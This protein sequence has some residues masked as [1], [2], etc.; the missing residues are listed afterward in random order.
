MKLYFTRHGESLA[1]TL[2]VISNRELPHPLTAKGRE[3]ATMLASRVKDKNIAR[4][5]A[6]PVPRAKE[7][8]EI[9]SKTLNVPLEISDALREYDCGVLEGRGDREAWNLHRKYLEDWLEGRRRNECP[10]GGE[11]FHD[12]EKRFVPFIKKLVKDYSSNDENLLLVSHG[13]AIL[14]GLPLIL[15]NIDF[16]SARLLPLDNTVIITTESSRD[17]LICRT[18]GEQVL[19]LTNKK[20]GVSN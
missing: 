10:P 11:T 7:T 4:I 18:W 6:S 14:L 13:G 9:I 20:D 2:H 17:G 15:V 8:A 12:I 16:P 1:N 3:Q 5:Y 19:A